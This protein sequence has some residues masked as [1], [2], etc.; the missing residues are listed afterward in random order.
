MIFVEN[1]IRQPNVIELYIFNSIM[2]VGPRTV[3]KSKM[4]LFDF[5]TFMNRRKRKRKLLSKKKLW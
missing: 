3:T 2:R 1:V 5:L 4:D